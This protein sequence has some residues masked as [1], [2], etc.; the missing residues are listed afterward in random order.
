MRRYA[1]STGRCA[2]GMSMRSSLHGVRLDW[3]WASSG[4]QLAV[5]RSLK[6]I[7]ITRQ[8]SQETF[9]LHEIATS[10]TTTNIINDR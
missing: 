1:G 2:Q 7:I 9:L 4:V 3:C 6:M 5:R 10:K 8:S